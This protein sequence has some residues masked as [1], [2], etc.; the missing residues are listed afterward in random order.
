MWSTNLQHFL[1]DKGSTDQLP[2]EAL[3]LAEYFGKIV[4]A[5]TYDLTGCEIEVTSL[6][7][8]ST[9][10]EFCTSTVIAYYGNS[11]GEINW[12]CKKCNESGLITGWQGTF[13]D[14]SEMAASK[15]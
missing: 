3:E 13:W 11:L 10:I 5:V 14:C 6:K 12:H 4:M 7:C 2:V 15:P 8:R 1:D 9:D